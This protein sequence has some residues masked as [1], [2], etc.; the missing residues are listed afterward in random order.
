MNIGVVGSRK[1]RNYRAL[2]GVLKNYIKD[3]NINEVKIIS[4]GA[5]GAD[6]MAERFAS[7]N[8]YPIQIFEPNWTLYGKKAGFC[9][10]EIIVKNSDVII[11]FWDGISKGTEST[12]KIAKK[13]KC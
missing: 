3:N 6:K 5:L 12:I 9:R 11:A 1:Y 4:G 8:N 13:I 10:N 7:E 2:E